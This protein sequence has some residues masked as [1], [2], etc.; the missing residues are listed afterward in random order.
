MSQI[1]AMTMK[2]VLQAI[3]KAYE[4][5]G[6]LALENAFNSIGLD[7]VILVKIASSAISSYL[8][9]G[10]YQQ[11]INAVSNAWIDGHSLRTYRHGIHTGSRKSWAAGDAAARGVR[12][13][14]LTMLG[15]GGY[16]HAI[17]AKDWGF[18][19]VYLQGQEVKIAMPF[20]HYVIDNILFKVKYPAEFHGQ[21]AVEAAIDLYPEI[22]NK[23]NEIKRIE[24]FTQSAGVRIIDKTGSLRNYADRDHC[25]QYMVAVA[26]LYGDLKSEYYSDEF[27]N[28][29]PRIDIL[30]E[31][32]VVAEDPHYSKLYLD[33]QHRAIPNSVQIFFNDGTSTPRLEIFYPLGHKQRRDA[34]IPFLQNKYNNALELT[35]PKDAVTDLRNLWDMSV[36]QFCEINMHDFMHLWSKK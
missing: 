14:W 28:S 1:S 15:E 3:I 11:T 7:H 22:K 4:I 19:A 13:A 12:L 31:K 33:S 20:G 29:D 21:T 18:N 35:F 24:I 25:I 26:L 5:Q 2:D 10:D 8:L 23:I 34:A 16:P 32:M 17:G 6:I 30:R 9:G 36:S 27:A